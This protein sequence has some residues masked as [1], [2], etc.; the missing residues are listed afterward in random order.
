MTPRAEQVYVLIGRGLSLCTIAGRLDVAVAAVREDVQSL[1][2][3]LRDTPG[4]RPDRLD[5]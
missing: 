3:E 2:D 1:Y 5:H 4:P